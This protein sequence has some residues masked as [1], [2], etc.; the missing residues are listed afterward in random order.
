[1]TPSQR[2]S[3][4]DALL[5][6]LAR[7][8][9]RSLGL[10]YAGTLR[11]MPPPPLPGERPGSTRYYVNALAG[12]GSGLRLLELT[13]KDAAQLERAESWLETGK[14]RAPAQ[15]ARVGRKLKRKL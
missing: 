8:R 1:M 10:A 3:A 5:S 2:Q 4:F 15:A 6:R 14:G 13:G 12:D 9:A 11:K 7:E